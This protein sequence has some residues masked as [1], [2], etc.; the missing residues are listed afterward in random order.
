MTTSAQIQAHIQTLPLGSVFTPK[1]LLQFGTRDN[2]DQ[3]LSRLVKRGIIQREAK[4]VYGKPIISTWTGEPL[5]AE[6]STVL[7]MVAQ[8][9]HEIIAFHGAAAVN[10]F[11]LSTQN[12]IQP[13]F[14]TTG[15]SRNLKVGHQL[16]R[17]KHVNLKHLPLGNSKAGLAITAMRYIGSDELQPQTIASIRQQLEPSEWEKLESVLETQPAWLIRLV[18]QSKHMGELHV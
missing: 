2:V 11:G 9:N 17:L 8:T 7:E 3:V 1:S 10:L 16:V 15:H 12:Q 13:V 4:G 5:P 18:Q 14:I 6:L